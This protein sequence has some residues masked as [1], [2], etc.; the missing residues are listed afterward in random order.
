VDGEL[1]ELRSEADQI[2]AFS[3]T[4]QLL[5]A[6]SSA[7]H[8]RLATARQ[9]AR[10]QQAAVQLIGTPANFA[11]R[12]GR[13]QAF[14]LFWL[15]TFGG[16]TFESIDAPPGDA[17][18][19]PLTGQIAQLVS[20]WPGASEDQDAH[21]VKALRLGQMTFGYVASWQAVQK[22]TDGSAVFSWVST[23][24][25]D[26]S[27]WTNL[28]GAGPIRPRRAHPTDARTIRG[29]A[30]TTEID[31]PNR[32]NPLNY[33]GKSAQSILGPHIMHAWPAGQTRG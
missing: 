31:R 8:E 7:T 22:D 18:L 14:A 33:S 20:S 12:A 11:R 5:A 16:L 21:Q 19:A 28:R 13:E 23:D 30:P 29:H 1:A 26:A 17:A 4:E 24:F 32:P 10:A 2:A 25:F 15:G 3:D 9:L 6:L 27:T